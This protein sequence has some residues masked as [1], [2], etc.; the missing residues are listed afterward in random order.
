MKCFNCGQ[1]GHL[2]RACPG[3]GADG[4]NTN[5]KRNTEGTDNTTER[6]E[7]RH[8]DER[9]DTQE[10]TEVPQGGGEGNQV[11]GTG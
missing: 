5:V 1:E 8:R 3:K 6:A 2:S 10:Q 9:Q 7:V 11:E 4:E